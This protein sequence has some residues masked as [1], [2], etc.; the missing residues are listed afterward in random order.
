MGKEEVRS[1]TAVTFL[2]HLVKLAQIIVRWLKIQ[3]NGRFSI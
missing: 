3:F 2:A 1:D